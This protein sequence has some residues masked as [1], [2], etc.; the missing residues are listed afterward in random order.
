MT[1]LRHLLISYHTC[2]T[3]QP[4]S[5]LAGGM[6]VVLL[7]F[8]RHTTWPTDVVT[9]G[10]AE[11]ERVTLSPNV[12]L[13]RLACQ[14]TR[15]WTREQAWHCLPGFRRA[16]E[17][18]LEGRRYD[19]ASA[20]YWMSGVLL[21]TLGC[22]GGVVFHT[23]QA[24]KGASVA[25]LEQIRGR[26]EE[27]L[28]AN[29]RCGFL[30]WHDLRN[31]R[32]HY[33]ELDAGVIRPGCELPLALPRPDNGLPLRFGWAARADAI[34]N[35]HLALQRLHGI[36]Q[37][38]SEATLAVAG[39]QDEDTA[40]VRYLGAVAAEE[41]AEFYDGIDQLWNLSR[42][43]TFGLGVLEALTRGATV[44]VLA[45]SDWARRLHRLG[46]PSQPGAAWSQLQRS[47]ALALAG[48][49]RWPRALDSWH[50]W[51]RSLVR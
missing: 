30:H 22:P 48:C 10:F 47:K 29:Y 11:Y 2:P 1:A 3:E 12:T 44:G 14:A 4:G 23:L 40:G 5:D 50:R 35:F 34:K 21:D 37:H 51:L 18:W 6:N 13:H 33:P 43:E 9:R 24:Q 8:L 7:G 15:P 19:V 16:L 49:Y 46:I 31:A 32:I 20:H 26:W 17:R 38:D 42:Y 27:R 41:M 45:D 25:P 39:S 28:V 36:R